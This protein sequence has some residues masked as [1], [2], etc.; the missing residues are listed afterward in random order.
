[1]S[2]WISVMVLSILPFL[3]MA[4]E[5]RRLEGAQ[6]TEISIPLLMIGLILMVVIA[7]VLYN[8]PKRKFNG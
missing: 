4:A 5:G 6:K 8:P 7:Y 2:K 3:S 1:M